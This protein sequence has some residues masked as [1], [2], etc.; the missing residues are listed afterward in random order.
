M[1]RQHSHVLLPTL[2]EMAVGKTYGRLAPK[3]AMSAFM[4]LIVS[5]DAKFSDAAV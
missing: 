3:N 1:S 2:P 5:Q 4:L